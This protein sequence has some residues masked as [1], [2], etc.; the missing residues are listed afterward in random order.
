[1]H[2]HAEGA[3]SAVRRSFLHR[4]EG[5]VLVVAFLLS[6]VI[7]LIDALG[8]PFH[9]FGVPGSSEYRAQLTL[10]LALL[11]G[12][13]AARERHH[14]TLSTAE[15]IGKAKVRDAARVFSSAVAA[16]VCAVLAY[17]AYGVVQA[18]REQGTLLAI[19]LPVWVSEC[20]MPL[21]FALL[22]G[23]MAWGAADGWR[24][25][26]VAFAA[27]AAAFA[28]GAFPGAGPA[29]ALPLVGL[30]VLAALV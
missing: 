17:S 27:I 3:P 21:A 6:M 30:I 24:G 1:M 25:R 15:A 29:L 16:A 23:R 14:L 18:D 9:G 28:L 22:A 5:D 19:G 10:W 8:R 4:F 12:L 13:L 11:G 2:A 26:A 20:V 7:P